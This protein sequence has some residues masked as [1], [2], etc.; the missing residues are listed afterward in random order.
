ML[1]KFTIV[2]IRFCAGFWCS[3]AWVLSSRRGARVSSLSCFLGACAVFLL[4]CCFASASP[5][6]PQLHW[7]LSSSA[8]SWCL[9]ATF[10]MGPRSRALSDVSSP[11]VHGRTAPCSF[12]DITPAPVHMEVHDLR[13][14]VRG[15][16][17][18]RIFPFSPPTPCLSPAHL[19]LFSLATKDHYCAG[20]RRGNIL[21]KFRF[22]TRGNVLRRWLAD[23]T[24]TRKIVSLLCFVC[25]ILRVFT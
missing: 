24:S 14:C 12:I 1:L 22:C 18:M 6:P 2:L 17:D 4:I 13:M 20:F 23:A 21:W 9:G 11:E 5:P 10:P 8:P 15:L 3:C 7:G 19:Q 16:T 25:S